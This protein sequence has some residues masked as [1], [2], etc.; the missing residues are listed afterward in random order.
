MKI[1]SFFRQTLF[2][3]SVRNPNRKWQKL[4]PLYR[5]QN[6][7]PSV[8]IL[9][10]CINPITINLKHTFIKFSEPIRQN[11][12]QET[13]QDSYREPV[14]NLSSEQTSRGY[15]DSHDEHVGLYMSSLGSNSYPILHANLAPSDVANLDD[16]HNLNFD[17]TGTEESDSLIC[18]ANSGDD[19]LERNASSCVQREGPEGCSLQDSYSDRHYVERPDLQRTFSK[20]VEEGEGEN[21]ADNIVRNLR[22]ETFLKRSVND[23]D[24]RTKTIKDFKSNVVNDIEKE[25]MKNYAVVVD[26]GQESRTVIDKDNEIENCTGEENENKLAAKQVEICDSETDIVIKA[27]E[28]SDGSVELPIDCLENHS[29]FVSNTDFKTM[30]NN[31]RVQVKKESSGEDSDGTNV[32]D[33]ELETCDPRTDIDTEESVELPM[34]CLEIDSSCVPNTDRSEI[35]SRLNDQNNKMVVNDDGVDLICSKEESDDGEL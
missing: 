23:S 14:Q 30:K 2:Q 7:L 26:A 16:L 20:T 25:K 18:S 28:V 19:S 13:R 27:D 21:L 8:S 22:E 34:D 5:W 15:P 29:S 32:T 12:A 17:S 24:S 35:L 4:S 31:L 11:S 1:L 33:K 3:N 10:C 9:R 6:N